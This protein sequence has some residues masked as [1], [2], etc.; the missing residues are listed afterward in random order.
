MKLLFRFIVDRVLFNR[1]LLF[2][3]RSVVHEIGI[4]FSQNNIH[5]IYASFVV[6]QVCFCIVLVLSAL[7]GNLQSPP[8]IFDAADTFMDYYNVLWWSFR[9]DVY[10]NYKSVYHP[11]VHVFLKVAERALD[12]STGV[13]AVSVWA[14]NA[15]AP[16]FNSYYEG[17]VHGA[18]RAMRD[19]VWPSR[20]HAL[21]M[22]GSLIAAWNCASAIARVGLAAHVVT[23]RSHLSAQTLAFAGVISLGSFLMA[24]ERA[25]VILWVFTF[26]TIAFAHWDRKDV[27]SS[28]VC[29]AFLTLALL[30]KWYLAIPVIILLIS[31]S[32]YVLLTSIVAQSA[33]IT[34]ILRL[35]SSYDFTFDLVAANISLNLENT[36]RATV[37]RVFPSMATSLG[38][39][40]ASLGISVSVA[41]G[42]AIGLLSVGGVAQA[43]ATVEAIARSSRTRA[44]MLS[45]LSYFA[46]HVVWTGTGPYGLILIIPWFLLLPPDDARPLLA[47]VC[48]TSSTVWIFLSAC[49]SEGQLFISSGFWSGQEEVKIS[50]AL[51]RTA[52][53]GA[54]GALG[55]LGLA[56]L[57]YARV[58]PVKH[59]ALDNTN[60]LRKIFQ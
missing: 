9:E 44:P 13:S 26:L 30:F 35:F 59:M 55:W 29:S 14:S 46:L 19:T 54:I 3:A 56:L 33:I 8:L 39:V 31:S 45:A 20:G 49:S 5:Y 28:W 12:L 48:A 16:T 43:G 27:V 21:M 23:P 52:V 11:V 7:E 37:E 57:A 51:Y 15:Q 60:E 25:N 4:L 32:R 42:L 58:N 17:M 1:I 24:L 34:F 36:T 18:T 53:P 10:V 40:L 47:L 50:C 2:R 22:L 41:F 6:V 38:M